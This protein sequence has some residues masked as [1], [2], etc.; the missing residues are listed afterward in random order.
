MFSSRLRTALTALLA[1][2]ACDKDPADET[3]GSQAPDI[4]PEPEAPADDPAPAPAVAEAPPSPEP[5]PPPAA[6]PA[7]TF[8]PA[9]LT[10]LDD[11][12]LSTLRAG[13]EDP[14]IP[15]DT[16]YIQSNE[17]RH[18]L[19]FPY[20]ENVG[21]CLIGVG[22]DQS[23]T[24]A[25]KARSEFVFMMDID[26]RVVD[27]HHMHRIFVLASETPADTVAKWDGAN[28]EASAALLLEKLPEAGFDESRIRRILRGYKAG[29]ETVFRHL[30]RVVARTR[31]GAPATWLSDPEMYEHIRSLY[32]TDRLRIMQGNL[33]GSNS[34]RTAAKACE[35]LGQTM[36]TIYMSNAEEYFAYTADFVENITS[37]PIDDKS[38]LL[39]TIYSK[40]WEHA[41][42]WAYQVHALP[43]FKT[44]LGDKKNRKRTAMLRYA[45]QDGGLERE[46]LQI[47]GFSRIGFGAAEQ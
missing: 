14:P 33:A 47:E 3:R 37:Q 32:Q 6:P 21:G 4:A 2:A 29:R 40:K 41:D 9:Q 30:K 35:A 28:A 12:Q 7:P 31:D 16:H 17:T 15:V 19:F 24:V 10:A 46:S 44:R 8:G 38:V 23:F 18:D 36:R 42:L 26:S 39:R 5:A 13:E 22:S 43:D 27:L 45:Q 11:A 20:V 1:L 25:A 34:M